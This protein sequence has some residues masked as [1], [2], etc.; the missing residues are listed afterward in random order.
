MSCSNV[1]S[2]FEQYRNKA[3]EIYFSMEP[4]LFYKILKKEI[5]NAEKKAANSFAV[6]YAKDIMEKRSAIFGH[7][8]A[9]AKKVAI[10][11]AAIVYA[12][13]QNANR[14]EDIVEAALIA[15]FL[16][17]IKRDEQNHPFRGAQEAC[18]LMKGI[19]SERQE[20]MIGFAIRNHEAFKEPL[21]VDDEDFML[22]SNALYDADK[23]RWGPDNFMYTIWDMAE[24]FNAEISSIMR[25]YQKGMEGIAKIKSTFRTRTGKTFGP[26]FIEAGLEIGH[27]LYDFYKKNCEME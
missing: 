24:C 4:P 11:S 23:F 7:G 3:R 21:C 6:A 2:P 10:E 19:V 5:E 12:E 25:R 14:V 9:H 27:R 17:D 16:H 13:C 1:P 22:C 20:M 26:D 8:F 18:S 15:G